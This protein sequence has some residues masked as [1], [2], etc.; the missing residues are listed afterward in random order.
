MRLLAIGYG[1]PDPAIDNYNVLTAPSYSDYD[2]LFVDPASITATVQEVLSEG[3]EYEAF[4]RRPVLNV[5][6]SPTAASMADQLRRRTEETQRLLE[7]GGIVFVAGRPNLAITGVAGFEG[8]DRYSW[9]P[10]PAGMA[11]GP[12]FLKAAEGRQLRI[13]IDDHSAARIIRE[14]RS[15]LQYRATFDDRQPPFQHAAPRVIATGGSGVAVAVE[16]RIL[17]GRIIFLPPFPDEIGGIRSKCADYVVEAARTLLSVANPTPEPVWARSFAVPGLEQVEAE[18]E[19]AEKTAAEATARL[20]AVRERLGTLANH[21]RLIFEE[22]RALGEAVTDALRTLGF[23]VEEGEGGILTAESEG[24]RAFVTVEGSRET[25]VEWPYIR[26]QRRLEQHLLEKREQLRG[27]IVVNGQRSMPPDDRRER[28]TD[29]LRIA[30]ENYRYCLVTGETLF[31]LVQRALGSADH[32]A[33]TGIRRRLVATNGL[34]ET[35]NAL[36][37]VEQGKDSGPIF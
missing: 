27:I 18:A 11:W 37:E 35:A 19:E 29:A 4:D 7:A 9:L 31:A 12:P 32:G 34:L 26:L 3:K 20:D 2:A 17:G 5:P 28:F 36:G 24:V 6:G 15:E 21:R 33:L 23:V 10:A 14:L 25:V 16:F 13:A 22:G 1:M 8:C 30:C